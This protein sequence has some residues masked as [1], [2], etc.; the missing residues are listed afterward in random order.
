MK[1]VMTVQTVWQK[2]NEHH[3]DLITP[4]GENICI[5]MSSENVILRKR[6]VTTAGTVKLNISIFIERI[7]TR[8]LPQTRVSYTY[9]YVF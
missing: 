8:L 3:I 5:I 9:V 4:K 6:A 2:K 1:S 7:T